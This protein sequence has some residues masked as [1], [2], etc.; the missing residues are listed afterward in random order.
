VIFRKGDNI[1]IAD[2]K[3]AT[4]GHVVT[5]YGPVGMLGPTGVKAYPG[6][7]PDDP[8]RPVT[9]D[10]LINGQVP[11]GNGGFIAPAVQLT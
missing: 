5:S 3:G 2:G 7:K 6:S 11:N 4:K 1:V 8:G 9:H 10:M